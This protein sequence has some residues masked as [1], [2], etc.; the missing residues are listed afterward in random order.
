MLAI[1]EPR[2]KPK[3]ERFFRPLRDDISFCFISQHFV[4]GYFRWVPP[5][6]KSWYHRR[7]ALLQQDELVFDMQLRLS[8][9]NESRRFRNCGA[10]CQRQM[11]GRSKSYCSKCWSNELAG[12]FTRSRLTFCSR[13]FRRSA[14]TRSRIAGLISAGAA[15]D[16]CNGS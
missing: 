10:R 12:I 4:M 14:G 1:A 13:V 7:V 11:V 3:A 9:D 15:N 5:G 2:A 8:L 16:Q 6:Q